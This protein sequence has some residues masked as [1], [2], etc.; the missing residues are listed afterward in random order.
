MRGSRGARA[1]PVPSPPPL[2]ETPPPPP[3]PP[4]LDE[5]DDED[6]EDD[7]ARPLLLLPLLG[8][9]PP[10]LPPP[11]PLPPLDEGAR[12]LP[13]AP[14]GLLRPFPGRCF[15][16]AAA[17]DD[18]SAGSA[19]SPAPEKRGATVDCRTMV[20]TR[21]RAQGSRAS[22]H[23]RHHTYGQVVSKKVPTLFCAGWKK[24][25]RRGLGKGFAGRA[26]DRC[27]CL[28]AMMT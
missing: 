16:A 27:P 9:F 8:L 15:T 6:D 22:H 18:A 3:P 4:C 19:P 14:P 28:T 25:T 23:A 24:P 20:V 21:N 10:G 5:D 13:N 17:G 12:L 11:A 2:A 1:V 26:R 7:D